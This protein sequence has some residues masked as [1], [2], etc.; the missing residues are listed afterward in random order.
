[1]HLTP[2]PGLAGDVTRKP[3][4]NEPTPAMTYAQYAKEVELRTHEEDLLQSEILK[5]LL[6]RWL[7]EKD[8]KLLEKDR[9]LAPLAI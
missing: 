7:L 8:L 9:A 4:S 2:D 1:M 3:M 6:R 5:M